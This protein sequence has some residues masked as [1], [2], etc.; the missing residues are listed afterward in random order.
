MFHT[1]R[2]ETAFSLLKRGIIGIFHRISIK[3]LHRYLAEFQYRFNA[4]NDADRFE[5]MVRRLLQTA[6]MQ[7][8]QLIADPVSAEKAVLSLP[9]FSSR[10]SRGSPA[11]LSAALPAIETDDR[12]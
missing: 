10:Q 1:N 11:L 7:Y 8:R 6:T 9:L 2:I 3:H 4:R 12:I 5:R